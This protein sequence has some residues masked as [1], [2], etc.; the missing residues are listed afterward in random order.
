ML[1]NTVYFFYDF[2]LNEMK[3]EI[4]NNNNNNKKNTY[5]NHLIKSNIF[6]LNELKIASKIRNLNTSTNF[7]YY[8]F[9]CYEYL[10]IA[11][12]GSVNLDPAIVKSNANQFLLTFKKREL[13]YLDSYLKALSSSKKY[14][15]ELIEF[16]R[17]LLKSIDLLVCNKLIHNNIHFNTI[18]VDLVECRPILTNFMYSL[19][20]SNKAMDWWNQYFLL[21]KMDIFCP[22]EFYLLQY[23][24]T[25]KLTSLS[26][27]N[28]ET[29]I[30]QFIK[31]HT[32]LNAFSKE[33]VNLLDD[34]L[35]YFASY[36]NK[37][38]VTNVQDMLKYYWTLDNYAL[39]ICYLK[40][41]IGIHRTVKT[42]NKF[43]IYFMKLL[44][45][46]ISLDPSKRFTPEH[47]LKSF[48]TMLKQIEV[49]D[50]K[51]VI[52]LL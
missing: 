49:N 11:E 50:F 31:D 3:N 9:D 14:I 27:Y 43:I 24:V 15:F 4:E 47:S 8:I 22:V 33:T 34:G 21:K 6:S 40:I 44:V 52:D 25:N 37:P 46:C 45:S 16:Y 10:K 36:T 32:L 26:P 39:S 2:S 48:D 28:I 17:Y 5:V 30:K 51:E 23:Q 41:L 42:N 35:K 38:F 1:S 7:R 18:V 19:D 20:L 29:V 13:I 12:I